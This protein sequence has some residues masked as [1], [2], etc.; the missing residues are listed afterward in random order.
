MV[1]AARRPRPD[2]DGSRDDPGSCLR[3]CRILGATIPAASAG[4]LRLNDSNEV[5]AGYLRNWLSIAGIGLMVAAFLSGMLILILDLSSG[6][7]APYAGIL[8]IVATGLILVGFVLIPAGMLRARRRRAVGKSGPAALSDFRLDFSRPEHRYGAISLS[9]TALLVLLLVI[10]GSY[11]SFHATES[12]EFCGQLCHEVMEPE[13]VRYQDSPHARVSCAEC[14]IGSGADWFVR[15]KLSGV[16]QI[17]AVAFDTFSRPIPTPI[18]DL[19]PAR[20]TCEECHWRRKFTGFKEIVRSY[21]LSDEQ[22]T[23][24]RL[25]MMVK[26]GGEK[27]SFLR[28]SGIHYH[29]LIANEV[30]YIATDEKRQEIAWVGVS[31]G[32]G[33]VAE[34]NHEENTL[35]EEERA[36]Y[37]VRKMDC[38]DCH[39]R[40]SHQFPT[41][42]HS[43]NEALDDGTISQELPFIKVQAVRALDAGYSTKSDALTAISN[44][45]RSFYKDEYPAVFEDRN[46]D[47][48]RSIKTIREIYANTV[49]PEMRASWAAYPDNIGHRDSPGCFR[50][51]NDSM[52][53]AS[54]DSIFTD[55]TRCHLIFAQGE[56]IDEVSVN[57]NRGLDFIHP[58]DLDAVDEYSECVECHDGGAAIYED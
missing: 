52:V 53:S 40:P 32:D 27:T 29:M 38:M 43:V 19:R 10:V 14:H 42:I 7:S 25:R 50:C 54:G 23:R 39:N 55:C 28:G 8:Y 44:Q 36:G 1:Y 51:H 20:E 13:W 4:E 45:L 22:N 17:F 21:Y 26:I 49:F 48:M 30:T 35:S 6:Q 46:A 24:H 31:R 18:R 5:R 11:Q 3:S 47:L 33:S 2:L 34:Y 57:L 41:P 15:A 12:V 58:E 9:A 56:S 37:E 16:R